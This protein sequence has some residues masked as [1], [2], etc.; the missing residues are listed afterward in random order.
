MNALGFWPT[1]A[2]AA[3]A[4]WRVTH[5]L[6]H[7][8]GPGELVLRL[9]L[10]LGSGWPGQLM[11]CFYCLSLWVAAPFALAL[12]REPLTWLLAWIALSGAAC[13]VQRLGQPVEAP[14][15]FSN[16]S[17]GELD[18][19]LLRSGQGTAEERAT[20]GDHAL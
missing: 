18:H 11:D 20:A 6:A 17:Q 9:R 13:L 12:T 14:H 15:V 7:E 2:L 1:F 5:L 8:D 19:G 3:L 16:L 4:T 10:R